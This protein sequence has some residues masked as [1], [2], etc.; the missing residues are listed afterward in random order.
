MT[1]VLG[2]KE[3]VMEESILISIKKVIGLAS[4][5][6]SFDE[7]LFMHIN[8][9]IDILRQLGVEIDPSFYLDDDMKTWDEMLPN[10]SK[11]QMI[12]TYLYMK[13]KKWFDPPQNGTTMDALN[14]SI[15]ELEW[16]IN[17]TVDPKDS[18]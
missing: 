9:A 17:V 4:N 7:D 2:D 12:K 13:V 5:D 6:E 1:C 15:A 18:T 16:R 8:S 3:L 10:S 14:T 11:L